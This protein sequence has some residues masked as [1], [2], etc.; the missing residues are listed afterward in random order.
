M[1]LRIITPVLGVK[2]PNTEEYLARI[3]KY[4]GICEST[5][6]DIVRVDKGP[7]SIESRY[8]EVYAIP[9]VLEIIKES[10]GID[11]FVVNCFA[12]P[13]VKAGREITDIPLIGPGLSSMLIASALCN[14][15]SIV[16]IL[17][18]IVPELYE[19]V[20]EY[21]FLEK[22]SSIRAIEVPVL[23]LHSNEDLTLEKLVD[24]G[25]KAIKEDG[26]ETL[27]LGCTG[28]TG[29]ADKL[30]KKLGVYVI[31]PLP[32]ALKLAETLASLRLSQSK[33]TYPLPPKKTIVK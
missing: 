1:K 19:H 13:G 14:R 29:M 22:L 6:L 30:S 2:R 32:T 18:N 9:S 17:D 5:E 12:D 10:K 25:K 21:G 27:I 3:R 11:G 15:F 26:A 28:F 7:A 16:T 4:S 23:E 31:D 33:I 8:D 24:E 20:R